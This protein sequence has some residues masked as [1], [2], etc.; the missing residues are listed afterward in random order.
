MNDD[1]L[2]YTV[3]WIC[4]LADQFIAARAILDKDFGTFHLKGRI[5]HGGR[6]GEHNVVLALQP[7]NGCDATRS[8]L[9]SMV[10]ELESLELFVVV[11]VGGGVPY[12]KNVGSQIQMVLGDVVVAINQRIDELKPRKDNSDDGTEND[13]GDGS[14]E[15]DEHGEEKGNAA[16]SRSISYLSDEGV[17]EEL[18]DNKERIREPHS[19]LLQAIDTLEL[20][21]KNVWNAK[22]PLIL[23]GMRHK[24][25]ETERQRFMDP[26][27]LQDRLFSDGYAHT[28]KLEGKECDTCCDLLQSR[29][30]HFR[31]KGAER[32]QDSPR[33]HY[34][35]LVNCWDPPTTAIERNKLQRKHSAIMFGKES[36][37]GYNTCMTH[38][39]LLLVRGVCDYTDCHGTSKWQPYAAATAAAYTKLFLENT[40]VSIAAPKSTE[41][42]YTK[43]LLENLPMSIV[44]P[45]SPTEEAPYC[46]EAKKAKHISSH[47]MSRKFCIYCKNLAKC[48]Y[49]D[50]MTCCH[51]REVWVDS[52]SDAYESEDHPLE[53]TYE[54]NLHYHTVSL[55]VLKVHWE[56]GNCPNGGCRVLLNVASAFLP[57]TMAAMSPHQVTI[58]ID[59]DQPGFLL[60]KYGGRNQLIQLYVTSSQLFPDNL[61]M[62]I[63]VDWTD[64]KPG[65][66]HPIWTRI[67]PSE[68]HR[69]LT[70]DNS[71]AFAR[72][73]LED[74]RQNHAACALEQHQKTF[75]PKRLLDI[76]IV[77]DSSTKD[78]TR[79][80]IK[81]VET[82]QNIQPEP[83]VA[84]SHRWGAPGSTIITET[85]TLQNHKTNIAFEDLGTVYQDTIHI[86]WRLRIRYVWIDSLCIVQ[87]SLEDWREQS[88]LMAD[89]YHRA[90]FTLARQCDDD[91]PES[92][93]SL[94][95]PI[96][97]L[98]DAPS[99]T[100]IFAQLAIPHFWEEG[101]TWTWDGFHRS[102][103]MNHFPLFSRGWI[104]QERLLSR[105]TLH[106]SN[107]E[108]SWICC[109]TSA[110]QCRTS[111]S[112]YR[113]D[114][115]EETY[116]RWLQ[117]VKE[118]GSENINPEVVMKIWHSMVDEYT[119]LSLTQSTDRLTAIQGCASQI[120]RVTGYHYMKGLWKETFIHDMLWYPDPKD[121]NRSPPRH[122]GLFAEPTWSWASVHFPVKYI[123]EPK[124]RARL[125]Q[126]KDKADNKTVH[127]HCIRLQ[128][129][130]LPARLRLTREVVGKRWNDPGSFAF[131]DIDDT[132]A[133][134]CGERSLRIDRLE[135]DFDLRSPIKSE[136][137]HEVSLFRLVNFYDVGD[138][139]D[140]CWL[141]LWDY[142]KMIPG[143]GERRRTVD[144]IPIYQRI[145]IIETCE[146]YDSDDDGWNWEKANKTIVAIE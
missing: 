32:Q 48:S 134:E 29:S 30:R 88:Q 132:R 129:E 86:L 51:S 3:G 19:H 33:I 100:P 43:L 58:E 23:R 127:S 121:S 145:G 83:Y 115:N 116:T 74:C 77:D 54:E 71:L 46:T 82:D 128:G 49:D 94:S 119:H 103:A 117:G 96:H 41:A 45:E 18:E 76:G 84:L 20:L 139:I 62:H 90:Y 92:V 11:G 126:M 133:S 5:Y 120:Q 140:D 113:Q 12:Y 31:G 28:S 61:T 111:Y 63:Y 64:T 138:R 73:V 142:G 14:D 42:A 2:R 91:H 85:S 60:L 122:P 131:I 57:E 34:G 93:R 102:S 137:V 65:S 89:I 80:P 123:H 52:P 108:L 21:N 146:I 53:L 106:V 143:T 10:H 75:M 110:C 27:P 109:E 98:T 101:V 135:L 16:E 66:R 37:P 13:K 36:D 99:S 141:I 144:G 69:D 97:Q 107:R 136:T 70:S 15:R 47:N 6:V 24:M 81:L 112:I 78:V 22:I 7:T 4:P 87:D 9:N 118:Q 130:L 1:T 25:S 124:V 40:P 79:L 39:P 59:D 95:S 17:E 55:A 50:M 56:S 105:R 68:G 44:A 26:G 114:L 38:K 8:L 72:N 125:L 67:R 104:Y 35:R